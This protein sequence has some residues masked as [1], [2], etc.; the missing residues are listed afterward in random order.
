MPVAIL[1]AVTVAWF[2]F[3]WAD[4]GSGNSSMIRG[5]V[6][7]AHDR[8]PVPNARVIAISDSDIQETR[9][10]ARGEYIFFSLVPGDYRLTA[11]EDGAQA[12]PETAQPRSEL[13]AG[14]EYSAEITLSQSCQ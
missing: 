7:S 10:N 11:A 5:V 3:A 13:S 9:T 14:M 2:P 4:T 12:C 8:R 1:L 6:R